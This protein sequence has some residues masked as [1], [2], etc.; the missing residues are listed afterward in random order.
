MI[1]TTA[2]RLAARFANDGQVFWSGDVENPV[3]L[4]DAIRQ[5]NGRV[6]FGEDDRFQK[7]YRFEDG[8]AIAVTDA[9]VKW[10]GG[11]ESNPHEPSF[12]PGCCAKFATAAET[13]ALRFHRAQKL[14]GPPGQSGEPLKCRMTSRSS[15]T[16]PP[17]LRSS[18]KEN[19]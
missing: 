6:V 11:W 13:F 19:E 1:E 2:T 3:Y 9:G 8:S 10:C 5:L 7:V 4:V 14:E 15:Y 12:E 18:D 17:A 16:G